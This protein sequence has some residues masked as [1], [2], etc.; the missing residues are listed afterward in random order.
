M[1]KRF[2]SNCTSRSLSLLLC[3]ILSL[4]LL[5]ACQSVSQTE[6]SS[7]S[8]SPA[9][10]I[11]LTELKLD[12]TE[13]TLQESRNYFEFFPAGHFGEKTQYNGKMADE[14]GGAYAVHCRRGL[15][16]SIEVK[17]PPG[18]IDKKSAIQV[19]ERLLPNDAGMVIEH[20]DEDVKKMDARQPAEFFYYKGGPRTELLYADNS[21]SKV[22]QINV[23]TKNG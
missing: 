17:Y 21:N 2:T 11:K 18:G 9:K 23:W 10:S 5:T 20:D 4:T 3:N 12:S 14:Y 15:P 7:A 19:M 13:S 16:F 22:V 1:L 8:N 6:T